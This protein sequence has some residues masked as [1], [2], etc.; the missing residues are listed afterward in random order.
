MASTSKYANIVGTIAL[1]FSLSGGALA[2]TRYLVNSTKQIS[3]NVLKALKGT[4]GPQGPQGPTGTS[5]PPG[6]P[7]RVGPTGPAGA[8]GSALAFAHI[9]AD[10]SVDATH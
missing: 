3:P 9:N 2:A 6:T 10:G 1:L 4:R 5:G 8:P 7:G